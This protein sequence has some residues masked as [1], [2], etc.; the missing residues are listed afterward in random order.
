MWL[1]GDGSECVSLGCYVYGP[2]W[3]G[4]GWVTGYIG[5]VSAWS[6]FGWKTALALDLL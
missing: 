2:V 6:C 1:V 5:L 3:Y 4:D